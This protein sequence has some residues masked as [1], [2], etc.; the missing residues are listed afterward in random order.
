MSLE[1]EAL[2]CNRHRPLVLAAPYPNSLCSAILDHNTATIH[3]TSTRIRIA[4]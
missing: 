4:S 1:K 3:A 2:W